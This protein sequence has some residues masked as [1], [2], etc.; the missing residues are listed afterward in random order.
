MVDQMMTMNAASWVSVV[1][2]SGVAVITVAGVFSPS[3]RDNLL[4]RLGMA[5][6]SLSA[7]ALID[8]MV[9]HANCQVSSAALPLFYVGILLWALGTAKKVWVHRPKPRHRGHA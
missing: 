6:A 2:L 8:Q 7:L 4:Q 3:Y 9:A 5:M 1:A